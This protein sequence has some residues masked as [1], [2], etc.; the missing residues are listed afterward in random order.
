[1]FTCDD[2]F[3]G[4]SFYP[5]DVLTIQGESLDSIKA[6]LTP[7]D[8]NPVIF[9]IIDSGKDKSKPICILGKKNSILQMKSLN[10]FFTEKIKDL[11]CYISLDVDLHRASP[12]C[13]LYAIAIG[14]DFRGLGNLKIV[15]FNL[16]KALGKRYG[17]D[18]KFV[19]EPIREETFKI[20][21]QSE[22]LTYMRGYEIASTIADILA[23][24]TKKLLKR[25]KRESII[26]GPQ[27]QVA[28]LLKLG[29]IKVKEKDSDD[30][31]LKKSSEDGPL[32]KL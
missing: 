8:D 22:H 27:S 17:Y 29:I 21:P 28:H 1:M 9:A 15:T 26:S 32:K 23:F 25:S 20:F 14:K 6:Q 11:Y 5:K 19:A 7:I 3:C 18:L 2:L 4:T 16:L 12:Q 10:L 24:Q 13:Y 31:V 30:V